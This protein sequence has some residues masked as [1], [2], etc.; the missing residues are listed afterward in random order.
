MRLQL[1]VL[2]ASAI[3]C[4]GMLVHPPSMFT[5]E[6]A[7]VA[8]VC[9]MTISLWATG[10]LPPHLT[11]LCFFLICLVFSISRPEVVFSGFTSSAIWLIFGGLVIGAAITSTGLGKRVGGWIAVRL[12]GSYLK[13]IAG[14]VLGGTFFSFLMPSAMGRVVLLIPIAIAIAD[15]F[16]FEKGR[17]GRTGVVLAVILGSFLPAFAILPANVP[18]MVLIGMSEKL[19]HV[20]LFYGPYLFLHFPVL[21]FL[22]AVAI[23]ILIVWLFPDEPSI[24][25]DRKEDLAEGL[26]RKERVLSFTLLVLL[27]LWMTDFVHHL[28]P[29]WVALAGAVFLMFPGIS[30]VDK[31]MFN[32]KVNWAS[33]IFVAGIIGLG[34][35]INDS[36]TG[37]RLAKQIISILPLAPGHSFSN[38]ISLS[39]AA[40]A[41]GVATTLPAMPAVFTQFSDMLAKA[42]GFPLHGV[43]NLQVLGFSTVLFPYQA[44]PIVVG[45]QLSGENFAS[46]A[47][48]CLVLA[49]FTIFLLF[50]LDYLWWHVVGV[51]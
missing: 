11:S 12:H 29:A 30:I 39:L 22:K 48:I 33:I 18:N 19:Y 24:G 45:M 6:Q 14:L 23:I 16:G 31:K 1:S 15:Y 3:V 42:S 26:S 44:P 28:S 49:F 43:I 9:L 51:F 5:M 7:E 34:A 25:H 2:V 13:I 36:G 41:T 37:H 50:P 17:K 4:L 32:Q 38:F 10:L 8:A 46:A 35:V 27:I 47:K 20:S 21:G 40:T